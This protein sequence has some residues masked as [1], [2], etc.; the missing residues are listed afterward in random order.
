MTAK[1][2]KVSLKVP[3][4]LNP[5]E[6]LELADLVIEHIYERTTKD[7]T[8]KNGNS[9]PKYSKKYTNSLDFKNAGKT[10]GNIDLQLS[11][12]MLAAMKLLTH[13]NGEITIG[14]ERGT[15]ENAK[16][17]GNI[18]GTYGQASPIPGKKRDF[19]GI[20]QSKLRELI[21]YVKVKSN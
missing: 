3:K 21:E 9:F 5:D 16:A 19:L 7:N 6:R 18:R 2:Q 13:K 12:D 15:E 10:K 1:H 8:D 17:D 14:F 20:E 4:S 11:G